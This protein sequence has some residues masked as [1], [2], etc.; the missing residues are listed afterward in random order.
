MKLVFSLLLAPGHGS[1]KLLRKEVNG[2]FN[3]DPSL[4]D[5]LTEKP[6]SHFYEHGETYDSK[7]TSLGSSYEECRVE[8][9]GLYLS[10][11]PLPM[12]IFGHEGKEA[13]DVTYVNWLSL[14]LAAVKGVEMW[15]PASRQWK[16]AHSQARFVILHVLLEAG[17]GFL[18]LNQT[19]GEDGKPDLL[20]TMDRTKLQTVGKDAIGNFLKKLQVYKSTGDIEEATKMYDHFSEVRDDGPFPFA[21]WRDIVVARKTPRKILVQANTVIKGES[22]VKVIYV[23]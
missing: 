23:A 15:S 16:Q 13:E 6:V 19:V 10:C 21:K 4:V 12:H 14:C 22:K 9:V 5:P 7:F 3:F 18:K 2:S 8:C 1:G 11:D 17:N 20:L